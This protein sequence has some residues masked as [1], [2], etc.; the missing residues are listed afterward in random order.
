MD[1]AFLELKALSKTVFMDIDYN[2]PSPRS[3]CDDIIAWI[4][5]NRYPLFRRQALQVWR[6]AVSQRQWGVMGCGDG[7]G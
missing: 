6:E 5:R 1:L 3:S 7:R 4:Q 2:T